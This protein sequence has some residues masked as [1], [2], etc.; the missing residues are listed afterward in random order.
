MDAVESLRG[1]LLIASPRIVD[2]N[3]RRTVVLM[4]EHGEEGAMGLVLNRASEATV[5]E[6]VPD[7]GWIA[8]VEGLV[9][10]GGPVASTSVIVLAEFADPSRA[11]LLLDGELGF[12]PADAD[13]REGL[14]A[15]T[16]RTRVFA[17]H[18]GWGPGQLEAELDEESWIV[19]EARREDVFTD[20]IEDLWAS[21]LRRMGREY[22]LLATMP[23]D[24]SLN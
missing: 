2:L 21:V 8:E 3:F 19:G 1:K 9:H 12:I 15:A 6:A 5:G 18:S 22:A 24:P 17:G 10:V 4:A 23:L 14:A 20:D 13:D 11:A 7:L 16:R